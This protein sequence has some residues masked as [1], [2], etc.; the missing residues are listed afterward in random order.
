MCFAGK[1]FYLS[2]LFQPVSQG[3]LRF[4]LHDYCLLSECFARINGV[5]I[6]T[7]KIPLIQ[8]AQLAQEQ[9]VAGELLFLQPQGM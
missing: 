5:E 7:F 4:R 2:L 8:G 1:V 6:V 9:G 3:D